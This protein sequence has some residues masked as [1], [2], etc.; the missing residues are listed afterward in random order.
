[1]LKAKQESEGHSFSPRW[2]RVNNALSSLERELKDTFASYEP[3]KSLDELAGRP[4]GKVYCLDTHIPDLLAL[5][6]GAQITTSE[7]YKTGRII[8]QDKASC[9][10]AY[11]LLGDIASRPWNGDIIDGCAAPGNKT[12]HL[13]SLLSAASHSDKKNGG[14]KNKILSFDSSPARSK[15]LQKMINVAG[16]GKKVTVFPGTDFLSMDPDDTRFKN[17]TALLLDPSCSGSGIRNR[18]DVPRFALP[19]EKSTQSNTNNGKNKTNKKKRKFTNDSTPTPVPDPT[20][21]EGEAEE[22]T[23]DSNT[24]KD[25]LTKLSNIQTQIVLHAFKFPTAARVT[26]S[27]CSIHEEENEN[28][29]FRLL[30]SDVAKARGWRIMRRG[31]QAEGLRKWGHRGLK[32]S[33]KNGS[34]SWALSEEESD[35]CIRCAADDDEGTG[36]FFVAGFVR[37]DEIAA[38]V[39]G[40]DGEELEV[41][42]DEES[43][44]GFSSD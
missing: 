2:A 36:G 7:A 31:E 12:T 44:G 10:P 14:R 32:M 6:P 9:F 34:S 20:E 23:R 42:E 39:E 25:R 19:V 33:E 40:N 24:D 11:L 27:T 3:V 35:A 17:V 13:A 8:L 1:M 4:E 28:V 29:V 26:Y 22:E 38:E 30:T 16:L 41:D 21:A 15:T 37:D 5:A 18:E 43:W